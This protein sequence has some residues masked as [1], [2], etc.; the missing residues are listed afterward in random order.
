MVLSDRA[1]PAFL[2]VGCTWIVTVTQ[3][4]GRK[5]VREREGGTSERG[6]E[7]GRERKGEIQQRAHTHSL[8]AQRN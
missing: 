8:F 4:E 5:E 1:N 6:K 3:T 2:Y 7:R